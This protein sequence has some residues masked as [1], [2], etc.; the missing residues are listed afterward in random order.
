M[1]EILRSK[2]KVVEIKKSTEEGSRK[3]SRN[4][5]N[6]NNAKGTEDTRKRTEGEHGKSS[7]NSPP[8]WLLVSNPNTK[9]P[10]NPKIILQDGAKS[11][12]I[13]LLPL[14]SWLIGWC[15]RRRPYRCHV[16]RRRRRP[17]GRAVGRIALEGLACWLPAGLTCCCRGD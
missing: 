14:R 16:S 15:I 9:I 5:P 6:Y 17:A 4:Y 13:L 8:S 11:S 7:R 1:V 2:K 12:L 10:P 3:S